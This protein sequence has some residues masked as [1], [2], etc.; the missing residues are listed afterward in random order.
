MSFSLT[1]LFLLGVGYISALFLT[2]YVTEKGF[3]PARIVHHP[4]V[5]TLSLGVFA[6]AWAI[7]GC[8][9]FAYENG[10]NFLA[11]YL[12]ISGTFLLA[13]ILIAP[14]LRLTQEYNLRSLAD[15]LAY[16]YR[17][18]TVGALTTFF[19]L[20]AL[21]PLIAL[22]IQAVSGSIVLLNSEANED[23]L[24]FV[25]CST[26][27]LFAILFGARHHDVR[28]KKHDGLV[29]AIALETVVKI[30]VMLSIGG[31]ALFSVFNGPDD[32]DQWLLANPHAL[33]M[34]YT[35][36]ADGP[37]RSLVFAFF[38]AAVVMPHMYHMTFTENT[39]PRALLTAS[40]GLPLIFLIM[41]FAVP[42][43]L[44]AALKME[45]GGDPE[46]FTLAIAI[47][48]NS[49]VM[50]TLVYI[51][52]L[53]AASGLII[54]TTL[55]L[56]TMCIS[57]LILPI[58]QPTAQKSFTYNSLMWLQRLFIGLIILGGYLF[59]LH[60]SDQRSLTQLS[61]LAFFATTQFVPA[62]IGVLFWNKANAKAVTAGLAT[63]FTVWIVNL[64]IPIVSSFIPSNSA[65]I[66]IDLNQEG[67]N[68]Y[69]SA[70]VS[71]LV[72][73]FVFAS[74]SLLTGSS[75]E[76]KSAAETC[77]IDHLHKPQR[78]KLAVKS[79]P[80]FLAQLKKS[81]GEKMA[82]RELEAALKELGMHR[83][84]TRPYALRR[85]RDQLETNLSVLF[86]PSVAQEIV[87]NH[88]PY[89]TEQ[90]GSSP[91]DIH[92]I[93]SK[94]E[95][96][97]HRLSGLG[98]ELDNLR[99]FHRQTLHDLP[100]GVCSLSKDG[101]ILGWNSAIENFTNV[102]SERVIGSKL[103]QLK[104]PW[105]S[106]FQQFLI[107][108]NTHWHQ[109]Q[110]EVDGK[111]RSLSL[112]KAALGNQ[113]DSEQ[114]GNL[115]IVMED[116][117]E[118]QLLEA[119]LTHSERLASIGRLAAGV[120]HEVGNPITGI[121][122]LAQNM[123]YDTQD[124]QTLE[125]ADLILE[126]TDRVSRIVQSLVSFSHSGKHQQIPHEPVDVCQC[127]TDAIDL[128]RLSPKGKNYQ[129]ENSVEPGLSVM[130][131]SQRLLQVFV[132]ILGNAR[133][134]C[135]PSDKIHAF[136]E[137]DSLT[138]TLY[139][140]DQGPGIPPHILDRIFEPFVTTKD[141][142]EGT[143]L[144]LS[145]AYSIIEDHY[146]HISIESPSRPQQSFGTRIVITLPC[147]PEDSI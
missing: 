19:L 107:D 21:I 96:Y 45:L 49:T 82:S 145:L 26:M 135:Q 120:A 47:N 80:E 32:L 44:W 79:T 72:N 12:G 90:D 84:E 137:S 43:I 27:T 5:Y 92:F 95:D 146:G 116:L 88:L 123:R 13:P 9:G 61:L 105:N 22:Q 100:V 134:A 10:Y 108:S 124:E 138:A 38:V 36:L 69:A 23:T 25:F 131:D 66:S 18:Q 81:L 83:L 128:I 59:Y 143:G 106:F 24:A 58:Y 126:Q 41:A 144:G 114:I 70:T 11:Y 125:A 112:H 15:L 109:K 91:K 111:T 101:E 63:G 76:E 115:V 132:N 75:Q 53:S 54:V 64:Y 68:L 93:E 71:F 56:S 51:G 129:F 87:D 20:V 50:A 7:Y 6:S 28:K 133:D 57:H 4:A 8:V 40:W 142:G 99:R 98:V 77:I 3:I 102:Q 31:Y 2:A 122:C 113:N 42:L 141:P 130:G 139:I 94:L 33:D 86:G 74:I 37:W 127:V 52:G 60:L 14:I 89:E 39:N 110:L 136:S 117:T 119:E 16:R 121:A 104:E 55:A 67:N 35:P 17:S 140:E 85:L 147:S 34:L 29:M 65:L 30:V 103:D 78:W 97:R 118:I 1:Q 46:Y 73:A 48:A 62:L